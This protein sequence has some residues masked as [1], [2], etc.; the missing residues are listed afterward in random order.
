MI[1]SLL[2]QLLCSNKSAWL[3]EQLSIS[4]SSFRPSKFD[5][6]FK[7]YWTYFNSERLKIFRWNLSLKFFMEQPLVAI[8]NNLFCGSNHFTTERSPL[9]PF[10]PNRLLDR[11]LRHKATRHPLANPRAPEA[12]PKFVASLQLPSSPSN[13]PTTN[14]RPEQ[15]KTKCWTYSHPFSPSAPVS[16]TLPILTF[17]SAS[18]SSLESWSRT[19]HNT[20]E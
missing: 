15:N 2:I 16:W 1:L 8:D 3:L 18:S 9:P 6:Y 19:F 11:I 12:L 14:H 20:T 5:T 7:A 13:S 4:I 17:S 10:L